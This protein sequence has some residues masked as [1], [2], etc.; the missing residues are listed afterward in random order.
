VT[1][2]NPVADSILGCLYGGAIGDAAGAAAEGTTTGTIRLDASNW[3]FTDD[4]QLTLATCEA[5]LERGAPDPEAIA[6]A[7]VRWF[8]Q[9]RLTG[10]GSTTLKALVD[11]EAG[12]HWAL[13]GGR[14][15]RTAGNGAA[16]RIAP[17]A[18]LLD[19]NDYD[20]RR[21]L[22]DICRVTH[23]HDESYVGALAVA[24]AIRGRRQPPNL[25]SIAAQLPDS[26]VR[27]R[28]VELGGLPAGVK[29]SDIG[30]RFGASGHVVESVPLALYAACYGAEHGFV[31]M[32]S[33]LL[34]AGGDTDTN[35]SIAGQV[36]GAAIGLR[37][38]P[39][40][41]V[42]RLPEVDGIANTVR[43]FAAFITGDA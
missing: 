36:A 15:E 31:E 1:V 23:H 32:L 41:L 12:A 16:M 30:R 20:R 11:L 9:G 18:F 10:L 24:L 3:Q 17:V 34:A 21:T 6:A 5:I 37:N 42:D 13:A 29:P 35:A 26:G 28:I 22:R 27:D 33:E 43:K 38:L 39:K 25:P 2:S 4:T 19:P 7:M 40:E 8:R 14:G